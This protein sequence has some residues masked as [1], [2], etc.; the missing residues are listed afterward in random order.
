MIHRGARQ[1]GF[2]AQEMQ[3]GWFATLTRLYLKTL[4]YIIHPDGKK[5]LELKQSY[6]RPMVLAISTNHLLQRYPVRSNAGE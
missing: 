5:R 3:R 1:L 4:L 6:L 2:T